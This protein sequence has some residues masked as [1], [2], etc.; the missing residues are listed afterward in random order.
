MT[1]RPDYYVDNHGK[2][3]FYRYEHGFMPAALSIGFMHGIYEKYLFR[4]GRKTID[5]TLDLDKAETYVHEWRRLMELL[6]AGAIDNNALE[7]YLDPTY[8]DIRTEQMLKRIDRARQGQIV[9]GAVRGRLN[10]GH[11]DEKSI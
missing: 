1:I 3:M 2:D 10:W 7:R 8:L 4:M 9:S 5:P 11:D 6:A